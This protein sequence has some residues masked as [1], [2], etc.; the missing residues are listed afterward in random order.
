MSIITICSSYH[1]HAIT[2][3]EQRFKDA[4]SMAWHELDEQNICKD[5][6]MAS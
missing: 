4:A 2:G 3:H 1:E 5:L 6:F